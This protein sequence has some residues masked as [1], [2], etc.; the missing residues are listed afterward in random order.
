MCYVDL[1]AGSGLVTFKDS[2]DATQMMI[3][4]PILMA[5]LKNRH[6]FKK[7][8]F[9]EKNHAT[10]LDRRLSILRSEGLLTCKDFEVIPDDCNNGIEHLLE[11]MGREDGMHF[12][13]FV[14]PFSTEI[15]WSTMEKILSFRYPAFDMLFNFQPF[16]INRQIHDEMEMKKFFGDEGYKECWLDNEDGRLDALRDYYIRKLKLFSRRIKTI[17]EPIRVRSGGSGFYYDLIYATRKDDPDWISGINHL[18][19]VVRNISGTDVSL[20][21]DKNQPPLEHFDKH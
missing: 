5:S 21:F 2:H 11:R 15:E 20:I 12:L 3:G 17:P 19:E 13:L 18:G 4:S 7:C 9:F 8:F 16:G 1:F 6:P 10:D 14:D